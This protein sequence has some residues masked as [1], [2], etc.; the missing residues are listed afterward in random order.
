MSADFLASDY[1]W[2]IEIKTALD[3]YEAGDACVI[4]IILRE[5]DWTAAPFSKL[6]A[7]PKNAQPATTW[8][9]LD[10]A[11]ANIT[12]GIRATAQHLQNQRQQASQQAAHDQ[13][14]E[15]Y[16]QQVNT[17]WAD[18]SL[19]EIERDTLD[20]LR[21]ELNL[22]VAQASQIEADVAQPDRPNPENLAKY[23]QTFLKAVDRE[24]P[25]S[26]ATRAE[27]QQRQRFLHLKDQEIEPIE[28]PILKAK[29]AAFQLQPQSTVH[30][31]VR[32]PLHYQRFDFEVGT[33]TIHRSTQLGGKTTYT[34]SHR[35]EQAVGWIEDLGH[36]VGVKMIS[37]PG[38]ALMMGSSDLGPDRAPDE[39]PQHLVTLQPVAMGQMPITQAQW[40]AV[41]QLPQVQI[42]L[43]LDPFHFKGAHRPAERVSWY[44][45]VEFCD[46]LTQHTGRT[47]RLP[48]EAEW[49]YACRAGTTTPFH[50]GQTLTPDLANYDGN[51]PYNGGPRGVYREQT[52][53]VGSFT[54]ANAFGLY[55]M[56]GN[57]WEW[58]A[59]HWHDTY[60]GAPSNGQVW[61]SDQPH[62]YRVMRG[63]S[64]L[65]E[66]Q[67]CRCAV[68]NGSAPDDRR[69]GIG[70]RVVC[71]AYL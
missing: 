27:L 7:L 71:D 62:Q 44:E 30:E 46:R 5:V 3:R 19:S 40:Q 16:R 52:T 6:Q 9:T 32:S 10:A 35:S 39:A 4:P 58:C 25:L 56:H 37:L 63:G 51:I 50:W 17:F 69:E 11:F 22:S 29:A 18:G 1:C 2:D 45:A 60:Q 38:G 67:I 28:A 68:R 61:L 57:V 36:G 33:L 54:V 53:P 34:I 14:L 41:A 55:D 23:R 31:P 47:Y 15:R 26:A 70:F 49:E 65:N 8:P 20:D 66:P 13:A 64:W 42:P 43:T 59:D 12:Q 24:F 48:S 21:T